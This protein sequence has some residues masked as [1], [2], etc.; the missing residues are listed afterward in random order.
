MLR[1]Q[2]LVDNIPI[3][4]IITIYSIFEVLDVTDDVILKK[5]NQLKEYDDKLRRSESEAAL[6]AYNIVD[7][8]LIQLYGDNVLNSKLRFSFSI[9]V[10]MSLMVY[11]CINVELDIITKEEFIRIRTN[12]RSWYKQF[13]KVVK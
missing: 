5:Y 1:K 10:L 3:E 2:E 11:G 4:D 9:R 8:I 7:A 6:E 13:R 12:L